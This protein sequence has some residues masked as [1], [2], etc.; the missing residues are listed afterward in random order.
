[1][2]TNKIFFLISYLQ[3][4]NFNYGPTTYLSKNNKKKRKKVN[5]MDE[6]S[7]LNRAQEER[8]KI[9]EHYEKGRSDDNEIDLWEDPEYE[10]YHKTDE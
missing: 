2:Y 4:T 9:F 6:N 3:L 1:M 5:I 10:I 7:L 8:W